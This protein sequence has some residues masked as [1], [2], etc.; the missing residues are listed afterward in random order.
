MSTHH[1]PNGA[2]DPSLWMTRDEALTA[3]AVS[4]KTL[5]R[6]VRD[7]SVVELRLSHYF[8]SLGDHYVFYRRAEIEAIRAGP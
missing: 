5:R 4:S 6:L 3:L 1:L 2:P 8:L 7:G